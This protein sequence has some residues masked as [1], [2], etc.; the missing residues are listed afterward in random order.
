MSETTVKGLA[1]LQRA[2]DQLPAKIEANIMRGALRE[3]AKVLLEEARR[4]APEGGPSAEN[5]RIYGGRVGLL[6]D[7]IRASVRL[8]RGQVIARVIA[9]GKVK[10]GGNAYYARWVEQGTAA[11][12]IAAAPGKRLAIGGGLYTKV[13]HP[14]ARKQPYLRP[15]LDTAHVAAITAAREY[16]RKRLATKHGLDVPGPGNDDD[17]D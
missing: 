6:R 12:M 4:L 9:G 2:L 15:A 11:H 16:I 3:G 13:L 5:Q 14:G 8:K 10:G 17:A 7:S 1:D